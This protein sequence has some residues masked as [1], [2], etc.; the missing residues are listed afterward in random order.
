MRRLQFSVRAL[1]SLMTVGCAIAAMI[2]WFGARNV[3]IAFIVGIPTLILLVVWADAYVR[4]PEATTNFT[5]I[6]IIFSFTVALVPLWIQN[7]REQSRRDTCRYRLWQLG[8]EIRCN[9]RPEWTAI[10]ET[11]KSFPRSAYD[12]RLRE[13]PFFGARNTNWPPAI[14]ES[15]IRNERERKLK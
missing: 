7:A 5:V 3:S 15:L 1:L 8:I 6:L 9:V 11:P 2:H 10:V 4:A 14:N 12:F 13:D